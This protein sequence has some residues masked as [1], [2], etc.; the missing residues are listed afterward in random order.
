MDKLRTIFGS[1]PPECFKTKECLDYSLCTMTG[2]K[3]VGF[4]GFKK[5]IGQQNCVPQDDVHI[6]TFS[7]KLSGN[8]ESLNIMT[9]KSQSQYATV[10]KK[11]I[12]N[13]NLERVTEAAPPTPVW[14]ITHRELCISK[15]QSITTCWDLPS[16]KNV[17]FLLE[18]FPTETVTMI[19][20]YV[21]MLIAFPVFYR[22]FAS[23]SDDRF[24]Q[25]LFRRTIDHLESRVFSLR[26]LWFCPHNRK[27]VICGIALTSGFAGFRFMTHPKIA[28]E[29]IEALEEVIKEEPIPVDHLVRFRFTGAAGSYLQTF[30]EYS[31]GVL[32]SGLRVLLTWSKI[33]LYS[34]TEQGD[35]S[36]KILARIPFRFKG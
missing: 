22:S 29:A 3:D 30:E 13:V 12:H 6:L 26:D 21:G 31:G 9:T 33:V 16:L 35:E 34:L 4:T 32:Y 5:T 15:M 8:L 1:T 27:I 25:N 11:A 10:V 20:P 14:D 2:K 24:F 19:Y 7:Q 28:L 17:S 36:V 23:L 18:T